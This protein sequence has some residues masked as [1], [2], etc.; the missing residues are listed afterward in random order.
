MLSCL[1]SLSYKRK[2]HGS[3]PRP[4][5]NPGF[6]NQQVTCSVHRSIL[7]SCPAT[8]H[9]LAKTASRLRFVRVAIELRYGVRFHLQLHLRVLLQHV[10]IGLEQHLRHPSPLSTFLLTQLRVSFS[11][12]V[13]RC[14]LR[15]AGNS[16]QP[17]EHCLDVAGVVAQAEFLFDQPCHAQAGPRPSA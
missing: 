8:Y 15:G 7:P 9:N 10:S 12:C 2:V 5:A 13:R 16:A 4:P 3:S 11:G 6:R 1:E 14:G 17:S